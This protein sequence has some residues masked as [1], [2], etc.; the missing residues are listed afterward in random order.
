MSK[1]SS[2]RYDVAI[3]GTNLTAASLAA[4]LGRHGLRV[5]MIGPGTHPRFSIGEIA[6]PYTSELFRLL[7]ERYQVP[8]FADIAGFDAITERVS[9]AVGIGRTLGFVYH[10]SGGVQDPDDVFQIASPKPVPVEATLYR[11]DIDAH[12]FHTA[13]R[14]GVRTRQQTSIKDIRIGE[15]E[16]SI[17]TSRGDEYRARFVVD[18]QPSNGM[19]AKSAGMAEEPTRLR[20]HSRSL[21]THMVGVRPFDDVCQEHSKAPLPWHHGTLYHLFDGGYLW[22]TPFDNHR[23]STNL[24]CSVGFSLDVDKFEKTDHPD[25]EF[26]SLLARIPVAAAQFERAKPVQPWVST[27]RQQ[28][29]VSHSFGHRCC[30]LGD[31]AGEVDPFLSRSLIT[32]LEVVNALASRLVAAARDDFTPARFEYVERLQAQL[33]D[34]NDQ[35]VTMVYQSL[36]DPVLWKAVL[37]VW[38]LGSFLGAL[39]LQAAVMQLRTTGHESRLRELEKAKYAGSPFP[40]HDGY[41]Q[42]LRATAELCDVVAQRGVDPRTAADQIF[43]WLGDADFAPAPVGF[44][45]RNARFHNLGPLQLLRIFAWSK[46]VAPPEI[47]RLISQAMVAAAPKPADFRKAIKPSKLLALD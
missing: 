27:D 12:L 29:S 26:R 32:S 3:L 33:I 19:L 40:T 4:I 18:T 16:V 28:H 35:L 1:P 46:T 15:E 39:Q 31:A 38:E 30:V 5:L 2:D 23:S 8:E 47:G 36:A 6:I 34:V 10:R 7:A 25:A 22:T 11:Q 13:I 44:D 21:Y 45:D 9:R 14:Y 43:G 20:T 37:R 41:N 42:L 24:V 17:T